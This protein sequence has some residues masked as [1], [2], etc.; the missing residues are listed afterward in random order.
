M[1]RP[2]TLL[3]PELT[4]LES[5]DSFPHG[6]EF[7]DTGWGGQCGTLGGRSR[8]TEDSACKSQGTAPVSLERVCGIRRPT[9]Q[10]VDWCEDCALPATQGRPHDIGVCS[11]VSPTSFVPWSLPPVPGLLS[12]LSAL[13]VVSPVVGRWGCRSIQLKGGFPSV[14]R[15]RTPLWMR[16]SNCC[17]QTLLEADTPPNCPA[18]S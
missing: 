17:V 7:P 8:L 4:P 12:L 14:D 6:T 5:V 9:W 18:D 13:I 3:A 16:S 15:R 11:C 10:L 2:R 1:P